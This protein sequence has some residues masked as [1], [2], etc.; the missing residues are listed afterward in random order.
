MMLHPFSEEPCHE[1]RSCVRRSWTAGDAGRHA[2]IIRRNWSFPCA[3]DHNHAPGIVACPDGGCSHRGIADR[4]S[5]RPTTWPCMVLVCGRGHHWDEPFVM[6]DT[7]GFPG[8]Q[9]VHD[10]RRSQDRLWLFWPTILANSWESCLTNYRV[11]SEY[12]GRRSAAVG[13]RR[14]D[15]VEAR[16]FPDA[17]HWNSLDQLSAQWPEVAQ[18]GGTGEDH[19]SCASGWDSKLYQRLGWQPR[20]KPTVL[21]SGRI[22][23]PLYTDTFS[24]SIMAV[25]DDGGRHVVCQRAADR[26]GKYPAYGAAPRRR[27]AGGLHA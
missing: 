26:L 3:S 15:P 14:P 23:L 8:L 13:S 2:A 11:S 4:A 21:P 17:R 22:L 24:I 25:S 5:V 19:A 10:D 20:C 18:A 16:E 6:A 12:A 27:N 1:Y 7:P 9:H